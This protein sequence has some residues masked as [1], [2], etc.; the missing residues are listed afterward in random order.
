MD[1]DAGTPSR[2]E[3]MEGPC[4]TAGRLPGS[5]A[6]LAGSAGAADRPLPTILISGRSYLLVRADTATA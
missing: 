5:P 6:Q 2:P 1:T 3:K 4:S